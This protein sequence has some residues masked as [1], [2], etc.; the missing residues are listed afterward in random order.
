MDVAHWASVSV[1]PDLTA[2]LLPGPAV[3]N[4]GGELASDVAA[5]HEG[6]LPDLAVDEE[7]VEGE[8]RQREDPRRD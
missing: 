5:L 8:R 6:G 2:V 4:A 7:V 3:A 1:S